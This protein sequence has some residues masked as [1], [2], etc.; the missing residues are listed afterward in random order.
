MD[1]RTIARAGTFLAATTFALGMALP[2]VAAHADG[3]SSGTCAQT[4]VAGTWNVVQSNIP[5]DPFT[6]NLTQ[7]GSNVGGTASY[8]DNGTTT[9]G[10]VSGTVAG[11]AFH[12]VIS[13]D[14]SSAGD[15]AATV[16]NG[17]MPDGY[18]YQVGAPQNNATF[19]AT[20]TSSSCATPVTKD[21]C[22]NGGWTG[23]ANGQGAAFKN[24]GDCVSYVASG[25][26]SDAHA[27]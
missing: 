27:S 18:T 20:Q 13:W 10:T 2:A 17:T 15:Y 9:T 6:F 19:T 25:G 3:P 22:K 12:V 24:Q 16:T 7:P 8:T 21:Q 23:W 4:S 11:N 14:N 1:M 26:R 5:S